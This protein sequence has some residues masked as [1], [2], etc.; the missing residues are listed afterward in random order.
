M[1]FSH[2][3]WTDMGNHPS[4]M[5]ASMDGTG[6]I[7]L[8]ASEL[9]RPGPLAID[10]EGN[11]LYWADSRLNRIECSDLSGGNRKNLVD[12]GVA[13]P[14]GMAIFGNFLYWIDMQH[15]TISRADKITGEN[16]Y[17]IDKGLENPSDLE[18]VRY[19]VPK[20]IFP[21]AKN[22][23]N[24]SHICVVDGEMKARCS[25]PMGQVLQQD[26]KT[27][28]VP[29][30][31]SG[32]FACTRGLSAWSIVVISITVTLIVVIL[33]IVLVRQYKIRKLNNVGHNQQ[34]N[35]MML[36]ETSAE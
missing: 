9:D 35:Q 13:N 5:R 8:F 3:Y 10:V 16:K 23:G 21:C 14:R 19:F 24:C 34:E 28:R 29:S 33:M 4:I 25:C 30:P 12:Q 15:R 11:R 27:C 18:V 2:M 36:D 20:Y 7:K 31:C 17:I 22:K 1:Y 6:H 26:Q 32:Q